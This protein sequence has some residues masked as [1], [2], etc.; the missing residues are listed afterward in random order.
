[1][2]PVF[3]HG[4]LRLYLLKLLAESPRHG[5]EVIRL[6]EQRFQGLYAPSA[7]T[8]YPRLAKLEAE[9]LVTHTTEGGRKVYSLTPEGEAELAAREQELTR[10]EREIHDSLAA[11]AGDI[12][13]DVHGSARAL[14]EEMR[15]A[16]DRARRGA[17]EGPGGSDRF[18]KGGAGRR[19]GGPF[20]EDGPFGP[21]GPFG[22]GGP[23]GGV[24]REETEQPRETSG[25][26]DA[27]RG[28]GHGA[29]ER[30]HAGTGGADTDGTE[31]R[32]RYEEAGREARRHWEEA[33]HRIQERV[34]PHAAG[35]D[36]QSAVREGLEGLG[37]E[38]E[39]WS[40][41]G[42]STM[43][44]SD[45]STDRSAEK[46]EDRA[47]DDP[48]RGDTGEAGSARTTAQE[49][50]PDTPEAA[51]ER[52]RELTRLLDDLRDEVRDAGRDHGV[53]SAQLREA[54]RLLSEASAHLGALLRAPDAPHG[55]R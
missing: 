4:R 11:L 52:L 3:G 18:R 32:V 17:G 21:G 26:T 10:L 47:G 6:L 14:R 53:S 22:A 51:A 7:G 45:Q 20:G 42:G 16:A 33:A 37:R 40:R 2:P 35:G 50:E 49:E 9:G 29:G 36:W 19:G 8:V 54:G 27:R 34:R 15:R 46:P 48:H 30:D 43:P 39:A 25:D 1:M 13:E 31:W 44:W 55:T 23:F 12:R 5:Y 28:A 41:A 24:S 38:F